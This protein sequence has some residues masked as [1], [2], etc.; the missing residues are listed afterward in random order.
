MTESNALKSAIDN[1][2]LK[3]SY[4]ANKLGLS[5]SGLYKKLDGITEFKA[6]EIAVLSDLLDLSAAE[7]HTIFLQ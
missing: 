6:S 5:R 2:G 3:L 1:K 4:I 7:I